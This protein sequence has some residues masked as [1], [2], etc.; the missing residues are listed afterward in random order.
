MLGFQPC[1]TFGVGYVC[2]PQTWMA[3]IKQDTKMNFTNCW[4]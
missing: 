2:A 1:S 4:S 3:V